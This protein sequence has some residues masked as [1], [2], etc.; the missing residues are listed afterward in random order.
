MDFFGRH[1]KFENLVETHKKFGTRCF[2]IFTKSPMVVTSIS[3]TQ[4]K[5]KVVKDYIKE[6]DLYVVVHGQYLMNY[7]RPCKEQDWAIKSLVEDL[8]FLDT[9]EISKESGVVI[10]MGKNTIKKENSI[11]HENFVESII[12]VLDRYHG[13]NYVV[14][15]TSCKIGNDLYSQIQDL[16]LLYHMFPKKYKNR[17]KFCIDT[18]HIFVSG[19]DIR[20]ITGWNTFINLFD[21]HIGIDQILLVHLNDSKTPLNSGKDRHQELCKGLI[22]C[23]DGDDVLKYIVNFLIEKKIPIISETGGYVNEK[24]LLT[25]KCS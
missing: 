12:K 10:H 13:S 8:E 9:L 5:I 24:N 11:C 14:F 16:A 22:F 19:Y 25:K 4:S 15:E 20:T 7:C 18:C 21:H 23:G 3:K 1:V 2:Q 17:I 6:N